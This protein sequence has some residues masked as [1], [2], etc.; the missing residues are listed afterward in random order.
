LS[1][2][3]V[4]RAFLRPPRYLPP[5]TPVNP[6]A[7]LGCLCPGKAGLANEREP[8]LRKAAPDPESVP[9]SRPRGTSRVGAHLFG[10]RAT[11]TRGL[12]RLAE[13]HR[14]PGGTA[15]RVSPHLQ[16]APPSTIDQ[17]IVWGRRPTEVRL[18]PIRASA[19]QRASCRR[20]AGGCPRAPQ[21]PPAPPPG[22]PGLRRPARGPAPGSAPRCRT[23]APPGRRTP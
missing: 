7:R 20:T 16:P 3:F 15:S 17:D 23:A 1:R 4:G 5:A 11:R 12:R 9:T 21:P 6:L 18:S 8:E 10:G 19:R 14:T 2:C 13:P 22:S